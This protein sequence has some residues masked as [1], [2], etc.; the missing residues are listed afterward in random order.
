MR[1]FMACTLSVCHYCY[2][3]RIQNIYS[4]AFSVGNSKGLLCAHINALKVGWELKFYM[5]A[6]NKEKPPCRKC[7][8]K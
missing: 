5:P 3:S 7:L 8:E 4:I 1:C 2:T 6:N